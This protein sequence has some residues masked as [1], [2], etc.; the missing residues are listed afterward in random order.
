LFAWEEEVTDTHEDNGAHDE[1]DE[2]QNMAFRTKLDEVNEVEEEHSGN[3]TKKPEPQKKA[4]QKNF[5]QRG[6]ILMLRIVTTHKA[7]RHFS[8]KNAPTVLSI[9]ARKLG[10]V[11]GRW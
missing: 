5:S 4:D 8:G 6:L 10:A 7:S 1:Q 2:D 9:Q 11:A 3:G